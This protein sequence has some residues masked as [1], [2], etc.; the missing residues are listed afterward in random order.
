MTHESE[1]GNLKRRVFI[2]LCLSIMVGVAAFFLISSF[3]TVRIQS[4]IAL[5]SKNDLILDSDIIV[6]GVVKEVLPSKWSNPGL[7]KGENIRNILQTDIRIAIDEV[8][9]G[10]P[11]DKSILVRIDKGNTLTTN[12]ISDGY[13][14]FSVGEEVLLFLSRD[15]GDLANPNENYYVL[16]GMI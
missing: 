3:R 9:S 7:K 1:V 10:T 4:E 13:P 15:D 5:K 11:Y 2:G 6:R 16:T 8:F 12:V 14:D